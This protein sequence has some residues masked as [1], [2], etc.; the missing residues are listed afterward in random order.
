MT[1]R[2][3]GK[4]WSW[5]GIIQGDRALPFNMSE[6][7]PNVHNDLDVYVVF[8]GR[9]R[10]TGDYVI[11]RLVRFAR[12]TTTAS[13][14]AQAVQVDSW[15]KSLSVG[16]KGFVGSG[17]YFGSYSPDDL[18]KLSSELPSL[19]ASGVTMGV[20]LTLPGANSSV[21]QT[22]FSAAAHANFKVVWPLFFL[23]GLDANQTRQVRALSTE[24][25]LL[26][27]Y[28]ADDGCKA[29]GWISLLARGYNELKL[30]DPLHATFGSVNCDSPWL[31]SDKVSTPILLFSSVL[32]G[33]L[34]ERCA[35]AVIPAAQL[36]RGIGRRAARG[37]PA[38]HAALARCDVSLSP[39]SSNHLTRL[40]GPDVPLLENYAKLSGQVGT[41]RWSGGPKRDGDFRHGMPFAPIGNCLSPSM[42][43]APTFAAGLW[44]GVVLAESY[45]SAGWVSVPFANMS[46]W[47]GA[48]ANYTAQLQKFE[49]QRL[50][51]FGNT[52]LS[53][54]LTPETNLRGRAWFDADA[55]VATVVVV[56]AGD[57]VAH[58]TATI[59]QS[60]NP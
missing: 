20:M 4:S 31:F 33:R 19:V 41:G 3:V 14:A 51:K 18:L 16:G 59:R 5:G 45:F 53:L 60:F 57:S 26:G 10:A 23:E 52:R 49:P 46:Q 35:T 43:P 28:V 29:H 37:R 7:P 21:Q 8:G 13:L 11:H 36:Q 54:S 9:G 50:A 17:F 22:F 2:A 27:W 6:L 56:N 12:V 1:L 44:L 24:P 47:N 32:V 48:V 40:P 30:V 34:N 55:N 25:A 58:F 39:C 15:T 38:A 42:M